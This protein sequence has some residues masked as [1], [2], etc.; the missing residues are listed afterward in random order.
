MGRVRVRAEHTAG[1]QHL[2]R[3]LFTIHYTDL[4][5]A[6][7]GAQHNVIRD[8]EGI[9]HIAGGMVLRHIQAGEVVVIVLDLRAFINFKAHAGEYINDLVLDEGDGVQVAGRADLGGHRNVHRLG[10]VAGSQRRLLDLLRQGLVLSLDPLLEF[11]DGLTDSGAILLGDIAQAL[12]QACDLA[13]FAQVFLPEVRKL[14]FVSDDCASLL[15]SSAQLLD[16]F[17]HSTPLLGFWAGAK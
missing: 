1:Y 5:A 10:S 3:G 12:G 9:L 11:I 7:L 8:I 14:G 4:A 6:G 17:F 15:N 16:F 2:D 13:V